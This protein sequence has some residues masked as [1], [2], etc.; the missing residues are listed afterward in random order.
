MQD[1]IWLGSISMRFIENNPSRKR[2]FLN[3]MQ[4][5]FGDVLEELFGQ[6]PVW[7]EPIGAPEHERGGSA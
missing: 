4:D 6:R 2:A 7:N 5:A 1:A 3:M